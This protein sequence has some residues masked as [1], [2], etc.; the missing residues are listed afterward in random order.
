[1]RAEWA[2]P[3]GVRSS[4]V[5]YVS[6]PNLWLNGLLHE[7]DSRSPS[8]NHEFGIITLHG[9]E[10]SAMSGINVW[11]APFLASRGRVVLAPNKR[12]S[13]TSFH[14]S[15]F[16]WCEDDIS[17][18]ICFLGEA[19]GLT[20]VALIGH[21]LGAA[22]AVFYSGKTHDRR[23][24]ALVLMGAPLWPRAIINR[25]NLALAQRHRRDS[26]FHIYDKDGMPVS[27]A[28]Y[29]SY[30]APGSGNDIRNWIGKV[31][32][33]I[34]NVAHELP[35]NHLCN[36]Q[37]SLRIAKLAPASPR[38]DTVTVE[39]APHSFAGH[40]RETELQVFKWLENTLHR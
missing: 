21:S 22:E 18:A 34:L 39:G 6:T 35:L 7:S 2:L 27:A 4:L 37:A 36:E 9:S 5:D 10:G 16:E 14:K 25:K 13:G 38:V 31:R 33:P 3:T 12:N 23:I 29:L 19:E 8:K 17:N 15:L 11:L 1:M 30:W 40:L 32:V 24:A 20:R 26:S 28:H